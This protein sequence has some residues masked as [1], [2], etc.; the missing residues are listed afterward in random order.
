MGCPIVFR[1][2]LNSLYASKPDL[3]M[4]KKPTEEKF[5]IYFAEYIK[6]SSGSTRKI[7]QSSRP[8]QLCS[9]CRCRQRQ[10][11]PCQCHPSRQQQRNPQ[12]ATLGVR[13]LSSAQTNDHR[14]TPRLPERHLLAV[15]C[16][17][18]DKALVRVVEH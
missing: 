15:V 7:Q 1:V 5:A 3:N 10:S 11:R 13:V 2:P 8:H 16:Q 18:G 12:R 6:G 9:F 14:Q 4:M 17:R